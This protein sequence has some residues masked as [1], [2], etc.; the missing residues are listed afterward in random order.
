MGDNELADEHAGGADE[1]EAAASRAVDEPDA[2]D[3]HA[4]V[5]D[6]GGDGDEEGVI[7]TGVLE[8]RGTV[9]GKAKLVWCEN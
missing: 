3:G 4:D 9:C 7:N 8:E 6:V 2:G 1:Q 5:N